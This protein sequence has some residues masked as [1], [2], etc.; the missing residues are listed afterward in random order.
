MERE[1]KGVSPK[2]TIA[3]ELV[4]VILTVAIFAAGNAQAQ[5]LMVSGDSL[6]LTQP[7]N[8]R[9]QLVASD[10]DFINVFG[11]QSPINQ[12]LFRCQREVPVGFI[13]NIG[14]R[15]AGELVF[16]LKTP[17]SPEGFTYSTGPGG[18]NPDGQVHV[19][20]QVI[21]PDQVR[22][23]WED[24]FN[25]QDADFNDCV[26]DIVA[27]EETK[28]LPTSGFEPPFEPEKWNSD[29]RDPDLMRAQGENNC[30]NYACNRRTDTFAQPG[31]AGGRPIASN[32]CG[33]AREA[34]LAD[35]LIEFDCE[36]ACPGG[37]YKKALVVDDDGPVTDY[38]WY[39][40]DND[41]TWSHKPGGTEATNL[42]A[43]NQIIL[44]PR[45][46]DRRGPPGL[47]LNYTEFCGCFCCGNNVVKR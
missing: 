27:F 30:Y 29:G 15:E 41:G 43:S 23:E 5:R 47:G 35:G 4:I 44:D 32:T 36:S 37:S 6:F 2:A 34:A 45:I 19:R 33:E 42:D 9:V 31:R 13:L 18:R 24:L 3:T 20:Y 11:V 22:I 39:R 28:P 25:L 14:N 26:V 10:A 12:D 1:K 46:A 7:S 40:Q 17:E 8:V 21:S 38:H 16:R